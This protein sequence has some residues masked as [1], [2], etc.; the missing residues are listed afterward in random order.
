MSSAA[1]DLVDRLLALDPTKRCVALTPRAAE[2]VRT[3]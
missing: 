3:H 2:R 1:I